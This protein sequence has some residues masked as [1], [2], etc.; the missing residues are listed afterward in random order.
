MAFQGNSRLHLDD[1]NHLK[2]PYLSWGEGGE[3]RMEK[4]IIITNQPEGDTQLIALLHILFPEC[5][6]SIAP[7]KREALAYSKEKETE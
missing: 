6:I 5:E 1:K 7:N 4:I 2:K 3:Y